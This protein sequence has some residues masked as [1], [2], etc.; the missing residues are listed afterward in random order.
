V[1]IELAVEI[2]DVSLHCGDGDPHLL[3]CFGVGLAFPPVRELFDFGA[4]RLS[5][6]LPAM[7]AGVASVLW[8]EWLKRS[9]LWRRHWQRV[10]RILA[11]YELPT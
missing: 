8:F 9:A 1:H 5:D 10:G 11:V 4:V 7:V 2:A 6:L 3:S